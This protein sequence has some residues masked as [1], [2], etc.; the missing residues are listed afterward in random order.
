MTG[1]ERINGVKVVAFY[2]P[3][4]FNGQRHK[5]R[6]N[7]IFISKKFSSPPAFVL[8]IHPRFNPGTHDT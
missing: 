2:N 7:T 6:F 4:K 1:V 8:L 3:R 5:K